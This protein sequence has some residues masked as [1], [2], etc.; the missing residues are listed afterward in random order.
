MLTR[1]AYLKRI[2][3]SSFNS[4]RAIAALALVA[5]FSAQNLLA[6]TLDTASV[7]GQVIDP[8]GAAIEDASVVLINQLTGFKR[9]ARS[10]SNGY[11]HFAGLPLTGRYALTINSKGFRPFERKDM[12]L[13][14]DETA[15]INVFLDIAGVEITNDVQIYGTA[16]GVRSDSPQIGTRLD[17]EKIDETP[18]FG[19]KLTNLP[20][21]NS[22]VKPARGQGDLFLNNTLFVINGGGRRQPT[23]KIDGSTGDDAWGRQTIFTN[24]PFSALQEF[25]VLPNS[26]S[27]EY[28]R[29]TGGAINVVTKSG[30]NDVHGDLLYLARPSG[31]QANAPLSRVRTK[32]ELNQISGVISGPIIKD[33]THYLLAAEYNRQDRDAV[34]TSPIAPGLFTG[35]FRQPLFLVRLDHQLSE[36]NLLTAKF[37]FDRFKDTN[38]ADAVSNLVL[39]S[40]GRIFR[41]QTYTAQLG[42][43]WTLGSRAINEAHLQYQLGDPITEF[44]PVS[45]SPQFVRPGISTEGESRVGRLTNDQY[46]LNDTLSFLTGKHSLRVGGDV[47]HSSSGGNGQEFGSGFLLGQFTFKT[48]A[49]CSATGTNCRPTSQLTLSDVAS[50]TQ[51]FGTQTYHVSEWL[52]SLFAQD[53]YRVRTD[54]TLN[55]GVRYE[56]QTFTDDNNNWA[57]RVGFAYNVAG[58]TRTVLR[59]SYGIYYSEIPA[60]TAASWNIGGPAGIFTYTVSPGGLGF[61]TSFS[62]I[63]SLPAGAV[64][65]ARDITIQPG[66]RD[67]YR[68]FFDINRLSRY[69]DEL[70]NPYTQLTTFGFERQLSTQWFLSA[71]Y[72]HQRTIKI[73][74]TI[75]LNAPALFIRTSATATRTTAAA[76]ATRPITPV[77][78]GYRAINSIINEGWANYDALQVNL[79]KRFGQRFSLLA[80]YTYSHTINNIEADAPGNSINDVNQLGAFEK[81]NS[82]LD[83][84]HRA[85]ISGWVNLPLRFKFGG[86]TTLASGVPYN[87]TVGQDVNGDRSN[88]DRP[89]VGSAVIGRNAGRG[90]AIYSTNA[91]VEHEIRF[92]E[93]YRLSLR[94]EGYNIF[95]YS[96]YYGRNGVYGTGATAPPA[97]FGTPLAGIA[98]VDP[99]R[100]LQFVFRF[101]F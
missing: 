3:K 46:Q 4:V 83:Q 41:K 69:Q 16:E 66:R 10:D 78:N 53:S 77:P 29:T 76:D 88:T 65:P 56:R 95:N 28:G 7:R 5:L 93:R 54:L 52:W 72:V 15:T 40:A 51:S 86:V 71:D 70:L 21:L 25:T 8:A 91:F 58:D 63:A 73:N 30:T 34:I 74:R 33:R 82:L 64:L 59:G 43:T 80:S 92:S 49:G 62:P 35:E 98:N 32:D 75:D 9:E 23:F 84:R 89:F 24:I 48:N 1:H 13:R 68:Q 38:P 85:V 22:A 19:R 17:L 79:N 42:D 36:G 11:Y 94:A 100:E 50:F 96:N 18:V 26:F 20:L 81:G 39:P 37:N 55:L 90:S 87:I 31:L 44:E 45:P 61:P 12:V 27:A 67:Y 6:Q 97:L 57:P 60:N 2:R 99:A 14:A 101:R 47:I